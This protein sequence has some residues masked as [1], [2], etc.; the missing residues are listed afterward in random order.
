[1]IVALL[2]AM[3]G[4]AAAAQTP[5][6]PTYTLRVTMEGAPFISLDAEG[7]RLPE[8]A[9]DLAKRLGVRI[10]LGPTMINRTISASFTEASLESTLIALSPRA[11][12]DYEI[13]RGVPPVATEIYLGA[14]TE[15]E[16]PLRGAAEGLLIVGHT[17]ETA[18]PFAID[19][20]RVMLE[21]D[22]LTVISKEQPLAA[23]ALAI[24]AT[25]NVPAEIED[26]A[27]EL[28]SADLRD[29]PENVLVAL[30]PNIRVAVRRDVWRG[31]R[32]V[33]R[34]VVG[35]GTR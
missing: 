30:S 4:L 6:Q 15:P 26:D 19:P 23:V 22:R 8:I 18:R 34:F 21:Y 27:R 12:I 32:S 28:V 1:L 24:G 20:L 14:D 3:R 16:P 9:A 10:V 5:A 7:A 11:Y 33:R 29:T 13:R 25:L 17:E 2:L 31:T 35:A